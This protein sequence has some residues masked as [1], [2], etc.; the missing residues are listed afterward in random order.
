MSGWIFFS[1]FAPAG[2]HPLLYSAVYNIS[3][4]W[5]EAVLTLI[6]LSIPAFRQVVDRVGERVAA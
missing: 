4:I 6:I 3:Y 2:Q 1:E 5:P